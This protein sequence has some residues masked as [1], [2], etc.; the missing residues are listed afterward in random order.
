MMNHI[1]DPW[2]WLAKNAP[3]WTQGELAQEREQLQS[4]NEALRDALIACPHCG[5]TA[6][7]T[8][9]PKTNSVQVRDTEA[10]EK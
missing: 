2:A 5:K 7:V 9:H 4:C 6:Q 1:L 3:D 8:Q 10:K